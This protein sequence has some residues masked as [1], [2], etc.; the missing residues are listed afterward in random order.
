M[1]RQ[2]QGLLFQFS[3]LLRRFQGQLLQFLGLKWQF[4]D[5]KYDQMIF[6]TAIFGCEKLIVVPIISKK[7]TLSTCFIIKHK[8]QRASRRI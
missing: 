5:P 1:I 6:S 8:T 2:F 3:G 4:Y 7:I